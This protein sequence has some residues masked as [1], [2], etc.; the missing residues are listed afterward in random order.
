[1]ILFESGWETYAL[2]Y[3]KSEALARG[4]IYN[5]A[6]A[7]AESHSYAGLVFW[8]EAAMGGAHALNVLKGLHQAKG[9]FDEVLHLTMRLYVEDPEK[10][11]RKKYE[12][13]T[14]AT[15]FHLYTTVL[16]PQADPEE[17]KVQPTMLSYKTAWH[18]P[19]DAGY[20]EVPIVGARVLTNNLKQLALN[21]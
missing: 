21:R 4:V 13:T 10:G 11:Q 5:A 7:L 12:N 18:D 17:Y 9:P 15:K 19:S 1:M 14:F 2:N 3:L 16:N 20:T 6:V 8:I